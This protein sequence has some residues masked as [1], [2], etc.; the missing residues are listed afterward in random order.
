[1]TRRK[2][3]FLW[4]SGEGFSEKGRWLE[5]W[6]RELSGH[7]HGLWSHTAWAPIPGPPLPNPAIW[8]R[9]HT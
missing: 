5:A 7:R 6:A 2:S 8:N 1:M 3:Y 4:G 9:W